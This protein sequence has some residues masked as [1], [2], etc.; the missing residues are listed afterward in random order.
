VLGG[1]F[2]EIELMGWKSKQEI[3]QLCREAR[4]LIMPSRWRETFGLVA[5]EAAMSG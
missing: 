5:L 3:A 1:D 2:P 4:A